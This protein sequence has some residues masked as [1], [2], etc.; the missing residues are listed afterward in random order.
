MKR[1]LIALALLVGSQS[2]SAV[3]SS[4][5]AGPDFIP[6]CIMHHLT[7]SLTLDVDDA[8]GYDSAEDVSLTLENW[9][10]AVKDSAGVSLLTAQ[11]DR[12]TSVSWGGGPYDVSDTYMQDMEYCVETHASYEIRVD[13]NP[14]ATISL[15]DM[16]CAWSPTHGDP[17]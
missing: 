5:L 13:F 9:L 12:M 14:S 16:V 6:G 15:Y 10:G 11:F 2:A 17:N 1:I 3:V 8:D 4:T 7:G